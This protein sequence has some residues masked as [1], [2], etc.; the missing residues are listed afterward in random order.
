MDDG[1]DASS[2]GDKSNPGD[3]ASDSDGPGAMF[4]SSSGPDATSTVDAPAVDAEMPAICGDGI[5][6]PGETCDDG[7]T[8]P[9]DGC[10]AICQI[11]P[12]YTCPTA[13]KPCISTVD[14]GLRRRKDRGHRAV[15][16]RQH[17]RRRRLLAGCQV[18]PG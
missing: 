9:G 18:E 12:G 7:N 5:V 3:D 8:I 17:H 6:E 1:K 13:G 4:K 2:A 16:R 11:E 15:R 10:S 14:A